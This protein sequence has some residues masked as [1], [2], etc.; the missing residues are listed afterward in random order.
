MSQL[1]LG[2]R[3]PLAGCRPRPRWLPP[4][5]A[6]AQGMAARPSSASSTASE[7]CEAL[8]Q[9]A[10]EVLLQACSDGRLIFALQSNGGAGGADRTRVP[11]QSRDAFRAQ[12]R[13][14][15][16]DA[17]MDGRLSAAFHVASSTRS[18]GSSEATYAVPV[19]SAL[20]AIRSMHRSMSAPSPS[21]A[22]LREHAHEVLF[23]ANLDGRLARALGSEHAQWSE[24]PPAP[25]TSRATRDSVQAL[26][27]RVRSALLQAN[28]EGRLLQA[29]DVIRRRRDG[30]DEQSRTPTEN[31]E[32]YR[33]RTQ[34]RDV[35]IRASS[36]GRLALAL[37]SATELGTMDVRWLGEPLELRSH[38]RET[39]LQAS[40]DGRLAAAL[41]VVLDPRTEPDRE[42]LRAQA[43][44]TLMQ[45]S[46]TGRLAVAL[47]GLHV[48]RANEGGG[49]DP[50]II[51]ALV[52]TT[53]RALN[54]FEVPNEAT[55][56]RIIQEGLERARSLAEVAAASSICTICLEPLEVSPEWDQIFNARDH[57]L[58]PCLHAFHA[59]CAEGWFR[60]RIT[61]PNCRLRADIAGS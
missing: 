9:K 51:A 30:V 35:L 13:A 12:A 41:Q 19:G 37:G 58:L 40:A 43:R 29:L 33:L 8:R 46:A 18:R 44:D 49:S 21:T 4:S 1:D 32:V 25:T 34:A 52:V 11:L 5:A 53:V 15:L 59:S 54:A 39:L 48:R 45:A 16:F 2:V 28:L 14:A 42:V 57:L 55:A 24:P 17:A 23:Q 56:A 26:R 20:E 31:D 6:A 36:D 7:G 61:C 60:S 22:T 50:A 27:F 3:I 38:A 47:A 10:R